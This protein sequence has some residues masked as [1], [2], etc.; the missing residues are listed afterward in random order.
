MF[1]GMFG[2][3][4]TLVFVTVIGIFI[5]TLVKGLNEWNKN[6]HAPRLTVPVM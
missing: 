3:L 1:F 4:F 5:V 6:N 2:L